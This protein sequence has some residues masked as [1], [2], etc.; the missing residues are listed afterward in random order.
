[1]LYHDAG[2]LTVIA[3]VCLSVLLQVLLIL[4]AVAFFVV[5]LLSVIDSV[6]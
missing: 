4:I 1:M 5:V 6:V 3:L 2:S